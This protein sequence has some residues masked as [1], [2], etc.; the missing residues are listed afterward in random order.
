M[1]E[2]SVRYSIARYPRILVSN[3]FFVALV[4]THLEFEPVEVPKPFYE[5][6][7]FLR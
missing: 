5:E 6:S 4:R 7:V 1:I 2:G 3:W